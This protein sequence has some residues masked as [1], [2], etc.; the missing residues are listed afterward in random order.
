MAVSSI[1]I[2]YE[3]YIKPL[4]I[5]QRLQVV[6]RIAQDMTQEITVADAP[7]R[8]WSEIRGAAP[9]P[10]TGEDAQEWVSRSRQE[11]DAHREVVR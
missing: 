11:D 9:Y 10:L 5:M 6:E 8:S 4:S 1:D 3:Q 2:L 7:R